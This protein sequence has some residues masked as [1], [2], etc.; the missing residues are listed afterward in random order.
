MTINEYHYSIGEDDQFE[1]AITFSTKTRYSL[2]DDLECEWLVQDCAEDFFHNHDANWSG[3]LQSNT[4]TNHQRK[5][6]ATSAYQLA[7]QIS[8]KPLLPQDDFG[9]Q[10][11]DAEALWNQPSRPFGKK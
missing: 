7:E 10:T 9:A 11:E 6:L 1:N 2:T 3:V 5:G 8:G 4:H